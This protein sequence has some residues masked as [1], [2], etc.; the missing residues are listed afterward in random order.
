MKRIRNCYILGLLLLVLC[1]N[2]A[3]I[4]ILNA[5]EIV[6]T[7]NNDEDFLRAKIILVGNQK[8]NIEMINRVAK[9][10]LAPKISS[11]SVNRFLL[12]LYK[13]NLFMDI[14][15]SFTQKTGILKV[16]V[17]ENKVVRNFQFKGVKNVTDPELKKLV[18]N[19]KMKIFNYYEFEQT[20]KRLHKFYI[21]SGF[22]NVEILK[23][24]QEID[25]ELVDVILTVR[26][27]KKPK[28]KNISFVGNK[29]FTRKELIDAIFFREIKP[30]RLLSKKTSYNKA[31]EYAN[32]EFLQKFYHNHGFI[33]FRLMNTKI[34]FDFENN[35]TK[36]EF[37]I[38]EGKQYRV[39]DVTI[40]ST[41]NLND[42]AK[43]V[44]YKNKGR[45]YNQQRVDIA[46]RDVKN[47]LNE[48]KYYSEI[49]VERR[50][51]NDNELILDYKITETKA[52]YIEKIII[53]GNTRTKD[54]V[55][56]NQITLHE[57]DIFDV[58][59]IQTSY[60]KIYN[61]GF[62]ENVD[63][64]YQKDANG[65]II[66]TITVT[67]KKTGEI[68]IGAGYSSVN[69][70]FGKVFYQQSNFLGSGDSLDFGVQKGVGNASVNGSYYK[71]NIF[72]SLFGGGAGLFYEK[73]D[74]DILDYKTKEYGGKL[75]T[76]VPLYKDLSV[77]LRYLLKS[78]DIYGVKD[79]ASEYIK[80]SQGKTITS[81]MFYRINYDKRNVADNPTKGFLL[82]FSQENAGLGGDKYF[83]STELGA[84]FY[85][86]LLYLYDIEEEENAII[87]QFKYNFGYLFSYNKYNLRIDDRYFLGDV[88]GFEMLSGISPRD[89]EGKAVGGD[90]YYNGMLQV[91]FPIKLVKELGLKGHFFLDYGNLVN[92]HKFSLNTAVDNDD[93]LKYNLDKIRI[94]AGFGF[95]FQTPIAPIEIDFAVP[96]IYDKSDIINHVYFAIGKKF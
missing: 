90:Q 39:V 78:S 74:N 41:I 60:R 93:A 49:V 42:K 66:L 52:N 70:F 84:S 65:K 12:A 72:D 51:I 47:I 59:E 1:V 19:Q 62:F 85:K 96:L 50:K 69:G 34:D 91:E 26:K 7:R 38:D 77:G 56:R 29:N 44:I 94:S 55:I 43:S 22:M 25:N 11:E 58:S 20:A 24:I 54:S 5:E 95:S 80:N 3:K 67:E 35:K 68:N 63:L 92:K 9:L 13:T 45:I 64:A 61:L 48:L 40:N 28:I 10:Y 89:K 33:D 36:I 86:K 2:A 53:L 57:G 8:T 27:N 87:G 88:R 82:S 30:I 79:D 46:E 32:R 71:H 4:E 16:T 31:N 81:S 23:D 14:K 15:I 75:M 76:S 83:V 37:E 18:A 17:Q 73:S 21:D 6:N